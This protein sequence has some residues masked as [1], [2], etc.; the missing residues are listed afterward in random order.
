MFI[1]G[2][3]GSG[4]SAVIRTLGATYNALGMQTKIE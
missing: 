1:I 4:K 2:P 3:A